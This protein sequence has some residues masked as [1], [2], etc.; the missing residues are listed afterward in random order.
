MTGTSATRSSIGAG[1]AGLSAAARPGRARRARAR[2][3]G[4]RAGGRPRD[5]VHRSARPASSWTTGSTSCSAATARRSH[6]CAGSAP[7]RVRLQPRSPWTC[8]DRRD[9]RRGS[10]CPPLPPPWHLLAGLVDWDALGWRDRLAA[11]RLAGRSGWRAAAREPAR[12]DA[13]GVAGET[14]RAVAR[15]QRPDRAAARDAVGA[16][17]AGRAEPAAGRTPR[18]PPFVR[19]L[20]EM[21]GPD[22]RRRGARACRACRSTRCTRSRRAASSRRGAARCGPERRASRLVGGTGRGRTSARGERLRGRLSWSSPCRGSRSRDLFDGRRRDARRRRSTHA[23]RDA[24]L[25]DRHR[26]PVARPPGPRRAVRRP[27]RADDAVGVRQAGSLRRARRRT[28]RSSRAAPRRSWRARTRHSPR[29]RIER[30]ARRAAG[31][32]RG[33]RGSRATVVREQRATFSLAPG[34]PARPGGGRRVARP[35]AGRRLDRHRTARLRSRAR[36]AQRPPGRPRRSSV[37]LRAYRGPFTD[38]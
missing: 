6:S 19:V 2:A 23:A 36:S 24:R 33:A 32:A 1:F 10:P 26:Q 16:A 31:R 8:I 35:G 9:G 22:R 21:F 30:V 37:T 25:A 38:R 3:R 4:A 7:D 18:P 14:R 11:L 13:A 34:Q 17:R 15:A 20:A 28:C 5:R 12:G 27:A 29:S